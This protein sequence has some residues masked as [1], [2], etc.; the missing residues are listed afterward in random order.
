M[1][2]IVITKYS[3]LPENSILKHKDSLVV[4]RIIMPYAEVIKTLYQLGLCP[5]KGVKDYFFLPDN[6][7]VPGIYC[8][9][10]IR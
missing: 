7:N 8:F 3:N 9:L 5:N 2:D 4:I 1:G 10:K 6:F